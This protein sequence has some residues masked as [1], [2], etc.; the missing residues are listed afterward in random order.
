[1][2]WMSWLVWLEHGAEQNRVI[3]FAQAAYRFFHLVGLKG[4]DK[5]NSLNDGSIFK[6]GNLGVWGVIS[7]Y[8]AWKYRAVPREDRGRE[9]ESPVSLPA[10]I[11]I[12]FWLPILIPTVQF[13][14]FPSAYCWY[15]LGFLMHGAKC[16]I[17]SQDSSRNSGRS[18]LIGTSPYG[19]RILMH[20]SDTSRYANG[21]VIP[22]PEFGPRCLLGHP[23]ATRTRIHP[24]IYNWPLDCRK[25][26]ANWAIWR[27]QEILSYPKTLR[28]SPPQKNN[29]ALPSYWPDN[30]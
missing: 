7:L 27:I 5:V 2:S 15:F 19:S 20:P 23:G 4:G 25:V 1:M 22:G 3:D 30:F 24:V 16:T 14:D 10:S 6:Q 28:H 13:I 8:R 17:M 18:G 9:P 11:Y 29:Q 21:T 12:R 26:H